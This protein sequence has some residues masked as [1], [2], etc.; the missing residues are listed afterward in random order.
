MSL[1]GD[2]GSGRLP[3]FSQLVIEGDTCK[4]MSQ[5][6]GKEAQN[7]LNKVVKE[8]RAWRAAWS[9]TLKAALVF[10]PTVAARKGERMLVEGIN[11]EVNGTQKGKGFK[12]QKGGGRGE[13]DGLPNREEQGKPEVTEGTAKKEAKKKESNSKKVAKNENPVKKVATKG[14]K[15]EANKQASKES[16][17]IH[18]HVHVPPP[19][20]G[21]A[22]QHP[23]TKKPSPAGGVQTGQVLTKA[24]PAIPTVV[25][26]GPSHHAKTTLSKETTA[27]IPLPKPTMNEEQIKQTNATRNPRTEKKQ[28]SEKKA[29]A[30][31]KSAQGTGHETGKKQPTKQSK[32]NTAIGKKASQSQSGAAAPPVSLPLPA[33]RKK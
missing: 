28:R 21:L 23:I 2:G 17:N 24:G 33:P 11:K 30:T 1:G 15:N 3:S 13:A 18:V 20:D 5:T 4:K 25:K 14:P 8:A 29:Q 6:G 32:E 9:S 16:S 31:A 19:K 22:K 7:L 10:G 12:Q 27:G 26:A